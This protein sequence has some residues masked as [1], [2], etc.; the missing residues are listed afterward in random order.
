MV[1]T[2]SKP[3][4]AT[5]SRPSLIKLRRFVKRKFPKNPGWSP[6]LF[7]LFRWNAGKRSLTK[8]TLAAS[9]SNRKC[10][11]PSISGMKYGMP[12]VFKTSQAQIGFRWSQGILQTN[13]PKAPENNGGMLGDKPGQAFPFGAQ[14]AAL[15]AYFHV[16]T[17]AL[18]S[19]RL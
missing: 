3:S 19:G 6:S 7:T 18:S 15:T 14:T 8:F 17:F 9:T 5:L 12:F 4:L 2:C 1:K 10:F 11:P 13:L 16:Y